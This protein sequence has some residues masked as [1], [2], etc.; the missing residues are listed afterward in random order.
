MDCPFKACTL[1]A[2]LNFS[3]GFLILIKRI[4]IEIYFAC[5]TKFIWE[6]GWLRE[7]FSILVK[8]S[9]NSGDGCEGGIIS[10]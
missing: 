8:E 10:A 9:R 4:A 7:A 2:V 6:V 3:P 1:I 5:R